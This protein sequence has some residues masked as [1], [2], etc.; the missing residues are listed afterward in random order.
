[1]NN[2]DNKFS[3]DNKFQCE[4]FEILRNEFEI[5]GSRIDHQEGD[6]RS[7]IQISGLNNHDCEC[8]QNFIDSLNN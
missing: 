8:I 2:N 6:F 3:F 1:M 4:I 7:S 5:F